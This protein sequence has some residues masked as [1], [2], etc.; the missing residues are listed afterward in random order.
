MSANFQAMYFPELKS[1]SHADSRTSQ[2]TILGTMYIAYA[3]SMI[4]RMIPAIAGISI[5]SDE[6]PGIDMDA[7]G[8]ILAA[9]TCGALTG[10]FLW[11]WAADRFG[12]RR[13]LTIAL[14]LA[15][16]FV[17]LFS[18]SYTIRGFQITFFFT[19]MAQAAGWPSMTRIVMNW[20]TPQQYGRVW[21]ILSTSSRVGTLFATVILASLLA[22]ISWREMLLIATVM[23]LAAAFFFHLLIRDTPSQPLLSLPAS[24][25][26]RPAKASP[27]EHPFEKLTLAQ[28]I[29]RFFQSRR[30]WLIS[31]SMM[32]MTILW[33]FLSLVPMYLQDTLHLSDSQASFAASAMPL[34]SLV[35]VLLGGFV[36]DRMGKKRMACVI[37]LLLLVTAGCMALFAC[38]P[39]LAIPAQ[40][41]MGVSLFLLFLFGV[42]LSPC[43]YIPVSIFSI[44]FGGRHSGFLVAILDAMGFAATALFYGNCTRLAE[45]WGWSAFL[46]ILA[47]VGLLALT[48]TSVFMAAE[49]HQPLN[50]KL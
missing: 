2:I 30:F 44:D 29:P 40:F 38:L 24:D 16:A 50:Q 42:C 46:G 7:W 21:G 28:T 33:D 13:T 39:S 1:A 49:A 20:A 25:D 17:A 27:A 5:R 19:L 41:S 31:A 35:S 14:L 12:S 36:F 15:A 26:Q 9:G 32:T 34:G 23:G 11:G 47:V 48:T 18:Q 8:K 45:S 43:Y 4:L 37:A 22:W 6:S 3:V 10:K